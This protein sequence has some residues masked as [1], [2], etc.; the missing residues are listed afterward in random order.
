MGKALDG[1]VT[2]REPTGT[3]VDMAFGRVGRYILQAAA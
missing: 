1:K 2:W 3:F